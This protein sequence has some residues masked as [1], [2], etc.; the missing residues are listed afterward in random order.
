MFR[1]RLRFSCLA[2]RAG[3]QVRCSMS[4]SW[5]M[6][7]IEG[8]STGVLPMQTLVEASTVHPQEDVAEIGIVEVYPFT[9]NIME[10]KICYFQASQ[11]L[12]AAL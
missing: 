2:M 7:V 6:R 11:S 12:E 3:W 5:E 10:A 9:S 4:N 8:N 1:L